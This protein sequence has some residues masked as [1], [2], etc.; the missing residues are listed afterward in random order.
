MPG[1]FAPNSAPAKFTPKGICENESFLFKKK[2]MITIRMTVY[3][4]IRLGVEIFNI[5]VM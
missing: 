4:F 1:I 3:F 2:K 5:N